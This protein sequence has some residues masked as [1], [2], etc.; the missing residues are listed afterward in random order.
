MVVLFFVWVTKEEGYT[1][2]FV[3]LALY[4]ANLVQE[5]FLRPLLVGDKMKMNAMV[6]FT[7]VVVGGM[8]WGFSGMVLFIPLLGVLKALFDSNPKWQAYSIFLAADEKPKQENESG[9]K[10]P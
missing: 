1:V 2:L 5:N 10:Q 3:G 9:E 8:I 6:V 7:A 4:G